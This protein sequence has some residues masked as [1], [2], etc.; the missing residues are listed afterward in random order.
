MLFPQR[1]RE[2]CWTCY[3]AWVVEFIPT[4]YYEMV[5]QSAFINAFKKSLL[6]SGHFIY[7]FYFILFI[8]FLFPR[9][10]NHWYWYHYFAVVS[11]VLRSAVNLN[12][13]FFLYFY[14]W[15]SWKIK[16]S[17][18]LP[19]RDGWCAANE[20]VCVVITVLALKTA[21]YRKVVVVSKSNRCMCFLLPGQCLQE[22][23]HRPIEA[24]QERFAVSW[25]R[26]QGQVHNDRRRTRQCGEGN[27]CPSLGRLCHCLDLLV[28]CY[29]L[30]TVLCKV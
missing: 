23:H 20:F 15:H 5:N 30:L 22:T 24:F 19:P 12:L 28:F 11:F 1:Q 29:N 14:Q 8:Y 26:W 3:P 2:H 7:L 21:L 17:K 18:F 6:Q 13:E 9:S 10:S 16:W 4:R 25:A 27:T